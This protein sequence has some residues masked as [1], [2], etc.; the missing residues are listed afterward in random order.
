MCVCIYT[1]SRKIHEKVLNVKTTMSCHNMP[2][3][4]A[5][6]QNTDIT[7]SQQGFGAT[8]TPIHSWWEVKMVQLPWRAVYR[9]LTKLNMGSPYDQKVLTDIY[10]II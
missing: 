3:R 8:G 7:K 9:F 2:I 10:P 6:I 1:H 4:K 5:K